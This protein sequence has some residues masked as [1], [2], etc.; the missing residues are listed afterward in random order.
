M[1]GPRPRALA[2]LAALAI[3]GSACKSERV[4][5]SGTGV[6]PPATVIDPA[7]VNAL[8]PPALRDQLVFEQ[9]DLVIE[10]GKHTATYTLAVPRGW[11]QTSKMFAHLRPTAP[12]AD[13]RLEVGSNC[14]GECAPKA[15]EP[16]ADRVNFSPRGRGRVRKDERTPGS[17]TRPTRR[18]MIAEVDTAG[19]TLVVVT[20]WWN[21]GDRKYHTCTAWLDAALADA[22]P[23]FER[24]CQAVAIA[25]DD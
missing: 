24:A 20:A 2:A 3:A 12:A 14:D 23:A 1:P 8:V 21:D 15:W 13:A 22:A 16:I 11:A 18:T 7:A 10:R 19:A 6:G 17:P 5:S 4:P 9:R 25:G